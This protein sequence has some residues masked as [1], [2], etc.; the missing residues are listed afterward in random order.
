MRH[1]TSSS[2]LTA[3]RDLIPAKHWPP[4]LLPSWKRK[5][6]S[7]RRRCHR[8]HRPSRPCPP[9]IQKKRIRFKTSATVNPDFTFVKG[10]TFGIVHLHH[11]WHNPTQKTTIGKEGCCCYCCCLLNGRCF[12]KDADVS[13]ASSSVCVLS[14]SAD[15]PI[16]VWETQSDDGRTVKTWIKKGSK[17]WKR[18]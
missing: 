7:R 13:W 14:V 9:E 18:G 12:R 11:R 8:L 3:A 17:W 2:A 5:A 16:N 15:V 4:H 10:P 6:P 1:S